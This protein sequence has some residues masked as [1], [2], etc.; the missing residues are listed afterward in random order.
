[1]E[2]EMLF[3]P[4]CGKTIAAP[5]SPSASE[6]PFKS[7]TESTGNTQWHINA[8]GIFFIGLI[9]WA[10][11]AGLFFHGLTTP[12]NP[13]NYTPQQLKYYGTSVTTRDTSEIGFGAGLSILGFG[14]TIG[15]G[16]GQLR[17]RK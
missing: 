5:I 1:M 10:I 9:I 4:K 17:R 3:C 12:Y 2:S 11:G 14:L 8:G 6:L 15:G 16:I 7:S 13:N